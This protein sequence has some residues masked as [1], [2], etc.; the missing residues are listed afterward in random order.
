MVTACDRFGIKA[1]TDIFGEELY[2]KEGF[3]EEQLYREIILF[4]ME[5]TSFNP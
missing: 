2:I 3:S 4:V 5:T 1:N